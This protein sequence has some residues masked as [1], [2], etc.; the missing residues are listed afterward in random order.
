[1]DTLPHPTM[2]HYNHGL[3]SQACTA[4]RQHLDFLADTILTI[5]CKTTRLTRLIMGRENWDALKWAM[6]VFYYT[7]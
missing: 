4:Q 3:H 5:T 6:Q 7:Y 2:D 1:M